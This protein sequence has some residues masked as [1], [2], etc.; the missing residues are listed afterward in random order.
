[1]VDLFP[2]HTNNPRACVQN[3]PL[4]G[5]LQANGLH[6]LGH[7]TLCALLEQVQRSKDTAV[8]QLQL[9]EQQHQMAQA[10]Y[11]AQLHSAY[12]PLSMMQQQMAVQQ[13][14]MGQ[15]CNCSLFVNSGQAQWFG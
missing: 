9:A 5:M 10:Q 12:A 6:S 1:M 15:V 13:Q 8:H 4:K 7:D 14:Q 11:V 3:E 2:A